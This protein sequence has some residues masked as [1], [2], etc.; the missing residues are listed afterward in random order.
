LKR[1]IFSIGNDLNLKEYYGTKINMFD[2]LAGLVIGV[3]F[4][5]NFSIEDILGKICDTILY[6]KMLTLML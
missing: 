1:S 2:S 5:A 6:K 4:R 3:R